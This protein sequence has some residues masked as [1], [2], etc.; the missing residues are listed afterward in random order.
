MESGRHRE[1]R[2]TSRRKLNA[3]TAIRSNSNNVVRILIAVVSF[4]TGVTTH[5]AKNH[6]SVLERF[7]AARVRGKSIIR[8]ATLC[9]RWDTNVIC[10]IMCL[11]LTDIS[12]VAWISLRCS[13]IWLGFIPEESW[14]G[15]RQRE[16]IFLFSKTPTRALGINQ[17]ERDSD[18]LSPS[19]DEIKNEWNYT[20]TS[21]YSFMAYTGTAL[22]LHY[23]ALL[24]PFRLKCD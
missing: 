2:P 12:A 24:I 14:F 15:F 8:A 22:P 17:P 20:S 10:A 6:I 4:V 9:G 5:H 16:E 23:V 19:S 11:V 13:S 3:C 1:H 21:S 18:N 7:A